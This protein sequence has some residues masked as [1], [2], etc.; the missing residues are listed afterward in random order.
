MDK[1]KT[2]LLESKGKRTMW[3]TI[4]CRVDQSIKNELESIAYE[5]GMKLNQFI[6]IALLNEVEKVEKENVIISQMRKEITELKEKKEL[7]ENSNELE[8]KSDAYTKLLIQVETLSSKND[9][10]EQQ[11]QDMNFEFEEITKRYEGIKNYCFDLDL[12]NDIDHDLNLAK[13]KISSKNHNKKSLK[14]IEEILTHVKANME[15]FEAD[16]RKGIIEQYQNSKKEIQGLE[17]AF[18]AI[19]IVKTKKKKEQKKAKPV[20]KENDAITKLSSEI[21]NMFGRYKIKTGKE[22]LKELQ[23]KILKL[24]ENINQSGIEESQKNR[25]KEKLENYQS[26]LDNLKKKRSEHYIDINGK[27]YYIYMSYPDGKRGVV[28]NFSQ[29]IYDPATKEFVEDKK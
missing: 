14:K 13:Q 10:L 19:K 17:F 2:S 18:G 25:E 9:S 28:N 6:K 15:I 3:A 11:I 21:R 7:S 23:S 20:K 27:E 24:S 12:L 26:K 1:L 16:K 29:G 5:R 8:V 22:V 4:G